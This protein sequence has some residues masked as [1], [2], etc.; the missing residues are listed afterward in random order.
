MPYRHTPP[1]VLISG[2]A[3]AAVAGLA[4]LLGDASRTTATTFDAAK[5]VAPMHVWGIVFLAGCAAMTVGLLSRNQLVL[6]VAWFI[7]GVIYA[8]WGACFLLQALTD[9]HA[10]LVAWALYGL[11]SM[12]HFIVSQRC[13]MNR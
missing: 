1:V 3:L 6:S 11:V 10:S 12:T 7:G 13:W 8:W 5:T 9:P 2:P 4:Y